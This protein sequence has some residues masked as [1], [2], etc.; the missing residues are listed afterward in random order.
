MMKRVLITGISGSLGSALSEYLKASFEIIPLSIRYKVDNTICFSEDYIIHLSGKAHD[1]NKVQ[2]SEEYYEANYELTK[3]LFNAFLNSNAKKFIFI[4]SVKAAADSVGNVLTES[5]DPNPQT[6]YGKSKLMAEEYIQSQVIPDGKSYYILRPCMI[7]GAGNKGNLNLLYH[8]T[9]SGIPYPFGN[10]QNKRSLLSIEN[11]CFAIN[12]ILAQNIPS[13]IYNICDD[14]PILVSDIIEIISIGIGR[15]I[16][17][18]KISNFWIKF[19]AFL[20]DILFLPYNSENL[21]KL[22]ENYIVSNQK[23]VNALNKT[24]PIS[25]REGLLKTILGFENK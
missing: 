14:E 18:L 12:E 4:S 13:G 16:R 24:L 2:K 17:I 1:S 20:G 21:R 11:F 6:H 8:F 19:F 9:K 3:Q 7:Y 22:T 5:L 23:L 25:S 15:R 10:F